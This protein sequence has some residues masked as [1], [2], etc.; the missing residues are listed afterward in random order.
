MKA[1]TRVL[2]LLFGLIL[3]YM[4][5][6]L[7]FALRLQQHPL[8]KW[9]LY[10]AGCYFWQAINSTIKPINPGSVLLTVTISR[11]GFSFK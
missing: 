1:K 11:Y 3:P 8:P 4:I 9:I 10:I 2:L 6:V 7:V 5:F